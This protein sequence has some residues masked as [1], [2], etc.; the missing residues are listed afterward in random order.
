MVALIP[1]QAPKL[2]RC[3][4]HTQARL[5][6][7]ERIAYVCEINLAPIDKCTRDR[8]RFTVALEQG[9]RSGD[10]HLWGNLAERVLSVKH[11][12][13]LDQEYPSAGHLRRCIHTRDC[14]H[15]GYTRPRSCARAAAWKRLVTWS[16]P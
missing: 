4:S 1:V 10:R 15:G 5:L 12:L 16:L 13:R 6:Q 7:R 3:I 11:W 14:A 2:P 8:V 9:A